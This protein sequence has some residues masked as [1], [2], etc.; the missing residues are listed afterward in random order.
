LGLR[1]AAQGA[2]A[3]I[4]DS[5]VRA[6][7]KVT[8]VMPPRLRRRVEALRVAT[9]PAVW[10][11]GPMVDPAALTIVAQACRDEERL[12]FAYTAAGG[13]ESA[14]HVGPHRL[15][16]LGRRWSLVAYDLPRQ[17]WRTFRLDRLAHP[18][19]TTMRFQPRQL[20]AADAVAFVRASIES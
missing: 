10:S 15:V 17:D 7:A 8:Q 6:L 16:S 5:S 19:G 1:A 18:R 9:Q 3:G 11:S 20:P 2:I 13:E 4:E 12:R 14:R